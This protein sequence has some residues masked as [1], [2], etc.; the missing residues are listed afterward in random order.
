QLAYET[1]KEKVAVMNWGNLGR[2]APGGGQGGRTGKGGMGAAVSASGLQAAWKDTTLPREG[3]MLK[4]RHFKACPGCMLD[5]G[6]DQSPIMVD[7]SSFLDNLHAAAARKRFGPEGAL[8][9]EPHFIHDWEPHG[10]RTLAKLATR[11]LSKWGGLELG[12]YK[13]GSHDVVGIP[14][15]RVHHPSVNR[16]I[17][18]VQA[19]SKK[20]GITGFRQENNEGDLRYIQVCV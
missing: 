10:W 9:F 3:D 19:S 18:A 17:K 16:A 8:D 7:S 6:F 5:R 12:L 11:P 1:K 15:C 20:I 13:A 2:S 14:E 4:C